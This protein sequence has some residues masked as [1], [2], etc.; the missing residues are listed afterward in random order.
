MK[1]VAVLFDFDGVI[2][3]SF[4]SHKSAWAVAFKQLFG[5]ILPDYTRPHLTGAPSSEIGQFIAESAGYAYRADELCELKLELL[6]SADFLPILLPGVTEIFKQLKT[7]GIPYGIASNA[8]RKYVQSTVSKLGLECPVVLGFEDY[9]SP[10]PLPEPYIKCA[11]RLNVATK[12]FGKI[13]VFE[14][15]VSGIISANKAGM[16]PIGIG[17]GEGAAL[18]SEEGAIRIFP[19]LLEAI[20]LMSLN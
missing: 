19:S 15:S 16:I 12:N 20:D 14:D 6:I 8:P 17:R 3:D 10:K 18:L 7:H 11:E 2:V 9:T 4:D 13:F 1:P 5:K